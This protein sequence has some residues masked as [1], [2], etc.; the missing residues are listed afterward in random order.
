MKRQLFAITCTMLASLSL[1]SA[2]PAQAASKRIDVLEKEPNDLANAPQRLGSLQL[3]HVYNIQGSLTAQN[4][5]DLVDHYHFFVGRQGRY[6]ARFNGSNPSGVEML[7]RDSKGQLVSRATGSMS[8]TLGAGEY[9][10]EV[11]S[12]SNV[13]PANY[14]ISLITPAVPP[15]RLTILS[16][17]ALSKFDDRVI[18][19]GTERADFRIKP[20]IAGQV[21]DSKKVDED[22]TPTFNHQVTFQP[23][24]DQLTLPITLRLADEDPGSDDV[25]HIS[26][27]TNQKDLHLT[28]VP[29]SG[30]I[31]GPGGLRGKLGE[32]I[33]VAGTSGKKAS[34]TFRI[35]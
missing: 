23:T 18:G 3:D 9:L 20:T 26:P 27:D 21:M 2:N 35:D 8:F 24:V 17:K 5:R 22:D 10:L 28:Y 14:A 33:T 19:V 12:P 7:V 15:L 34:V 29:Q 30:E 1:L 31:F 6:L 4:N 13:P 25:A 16:A 32:P 11:R